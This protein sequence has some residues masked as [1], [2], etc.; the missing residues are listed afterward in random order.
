[1]KKAFTLIELIFVII[2]VGILSV[3]VVPRMRS[4][5]LQEAATQFM[6][7]IRYTQ[8][9]A[10]I[11]DIYDSRDQNWYKG[12]WQ[13]LYSKSN[14]S[15]RDTGGYDALTIFTDSGANQ[16]GKPEISEMARNP[17][18]TLQVLSG[19]YSG[20]IDWEDTNATRSMNLGATYGITSITQSGCGGQ[21][22]SFD[23]KGRPFIGDDS[24]WNSSTDGILDAQCVFTLHKDS[25]SIDIFIERET[26]YVHL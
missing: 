6:S 4:N 15:S 19:G 24:N 26:G 11:D 3:A 5:S 8:H 7:D 17:M 9:L 21:R 25:D 22:I 18:N 1:M 13:L 16:G 20:E 23:N 12:R 10:M 2:I 14:S